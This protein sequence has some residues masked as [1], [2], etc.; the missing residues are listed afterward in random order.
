M[1]AVGAVSVDPESEQIVCVGHDCKRV[2]LTRSITLSW[3]VVDLWPVGK[4]EVPIVTRNIQ[5][6][7][8]AAPSPL[9]MPAMPRNRS[10]L[11]LHRI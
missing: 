7:G 1:D 5:P 9:G 8:L 10:A 6:V 11:H 2:A 3:S 4:E